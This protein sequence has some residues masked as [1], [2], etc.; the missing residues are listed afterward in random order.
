MGD[1][2]AIAVGGGL[3][4]AA[5]ALKLA[6]S[7]ARVALVERTAAPTLK[8]CGDFLSREAQELLAYLGVDVARMGAARIKT[9]RLATGELSASAD[10]PFAAAGL[11]RLALDEALLAKAQ[12]AGVE[13]LRGEG[14]SALEPD[15]GHV[16]VRVGAK[17]LRAR[18]AALAT[19]KHNVR[20]F[21]RG[22]GAMTAYKIQ[23]VPTRAASRALD[24]AV[25]LVSYR[26]GYIGACKV[27]D[28]QVTICWLMD[29]PALRE[30]GSDW[31]AHLDRLARQSPALGD[32]LSGA[33]FVSV[34]P[35][36]VSAIPYGYVRRAVIAPNVLPLGD[37]LCVIPSFTGD[38][39]SLAL[40]SGLEAART[41]LSGETAVEFQRAFAQRIRAQL[42]W[43]QTVDASFKW[44]A[45]RGLG[46]GAVAALPSLARH[47][48]RATRVRG[49]EELIGQAGLPGSTAPVR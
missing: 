39:T 10:L 26:G 31:R 49:M 29:P 17:V 12:A 30:L 45:T 24:N 37:Q 11:T 36:T 1:F 9:L 40:S 32:L 3:A 2:D 34:R 7:G 23:F 20:G 16:R 27:E 46:V 6:R 47:I 5:F 41:I 8:V 35:A 33:R 48:A 22:P 15:G 25:Q 43:A 19:G 44:G 28:G 38:G 13:V 42:F 4:G 14:A 18:C 21:P